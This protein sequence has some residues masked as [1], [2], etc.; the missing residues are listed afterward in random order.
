[1]NSLG[2]N[3]MSLKT[4]IKSCLIGAGHIGSDFV[5]NFLG[6]DCPKTRA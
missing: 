6:G 3:S 1:M 2:K 4:V 5:Q